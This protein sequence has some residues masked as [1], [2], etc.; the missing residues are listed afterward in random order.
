MIFSL[1]ICRTFALVGYEISECADM[2]DDT[3]A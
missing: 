2:R 3:Q 1:S